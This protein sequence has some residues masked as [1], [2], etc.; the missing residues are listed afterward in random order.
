MKILLVTWQEWLDGNRPGDPLPGLKCRFHAR[1]A[2]K[3]RQ[4]PA[5][6]SKLSLFSW[7]FADFARLRAEIPRIYAVLRG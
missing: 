5:Y 7:F 3:I 4:I 6:A 2:H 1:T